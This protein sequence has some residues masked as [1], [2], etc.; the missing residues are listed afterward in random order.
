MQP[1]LVRHAV[2]AATLLLLLVACGG[3]DGGTGPGGNNN[4]GN[5]GS[6]SNAIDVRDNSYSPSSTTV[7]VGTT[8]TW[9]WRGNASHDVT[10]SS[11][12]HSDVQQTGTYSRQF[13]SAG[14]F[15]YHC[16]VHGTAMSGRVV[17]Q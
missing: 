1:T 16:S 9:T 17:V 14:T 8:V 7:P 6:T 5:G 3:D 11:T 15:D 2:R 4:G 12:E 13:G 10:F